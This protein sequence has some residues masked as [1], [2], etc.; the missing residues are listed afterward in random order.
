[1]LK[2]HLLSRVGT[3][4]GEEKRQLNEFWKERIEALVRLGREED[5]DAIKAW[6]RARYAQ[7][8]REREAGAQPQ[9]FDRIGTEFHRW[10]RDNATDLKLDDSESYRRFV[11]HDFSSYTRWYERVRRLAQ[12]LTPGFETIYCNAD[13]KFTL[14]Y[15]LMLAPIRL[16]EPEDVVLRKV[17]VVARFIDILIARRLWHNRSVDYS[18]MQYAMFLVIKDIRELDAPALADRLAAYLEKETSAFSAE[19]RIGYMTM[20]QKTLRRFLARMTAWVETRAGMADRLGEYL[21]SAGVDGYDIEHIWADRPERH[22]DEF[23]HPRDFA[24]TRNL[25]GGL[26]LLP[27]KFN[28]SYGDLPYR[29]SAKS[30]EEQKY[31]HYDGQN[32]LARSLHE[33]AYAHNPGFKALIQNTGLKFKPHPEFKKADLEARHGLY[34]AIASQVWGI[35][36][37]HEEAAT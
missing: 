27:K 4:D 29:D 5:A 1:M 24:E 17:R 19:D 30:P 12:T 34:V 26:L 25:I 8:T 3:E 10:V 15:P 2:S 13:A 31:T 9:D 32:L 11:R 36:R 18:T 7:T 23:S 37:L 21:R 20:N 14:Q 6:L 16:N 33:N 35:T 28:R 22:T